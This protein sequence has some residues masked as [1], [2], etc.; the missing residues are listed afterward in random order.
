MN[1]FITWVQTR[2]EF[3]TTLSER[4]KMINMSK[5]VKMSRMSKMSTL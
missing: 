1:L 5:M 3:I 4:S 2:F